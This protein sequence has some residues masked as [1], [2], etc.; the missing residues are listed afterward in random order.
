MQKNSVFIFF[1]YYYFILAP[2]SNKSNLIIIYYFRLFYVRFKIGDQ[3][4]NQRKK[5][6]RITFLHF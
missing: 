6:K 5:R 1:K 3:I 4:Q 2:N